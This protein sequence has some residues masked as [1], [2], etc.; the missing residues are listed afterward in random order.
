[1]EWEWAD[2]AELDEVDE[3]VVTALTE[4]AMAPDAVRTVSFFCGILVVDTLW[5][6][7]TTEEILD[8]PAAGG[9]VVVEW[10]EEEAATRTVWGGGG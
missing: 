8:L 2:T 6:V 1:M 7:S 5:T 10:P 3:F 4:W 9:L